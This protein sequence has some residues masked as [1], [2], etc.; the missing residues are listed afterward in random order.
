MTMIM[1]YF[2]TKILLKILKSMLKSH[3]YIPAMYKLTCSS[4]RTEYTEVAFKG[5]IH[6]LSCSRIMYVESMLSYKMTLTIRFS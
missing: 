3:E 6:H 1:N 4:K 2:H 5:S